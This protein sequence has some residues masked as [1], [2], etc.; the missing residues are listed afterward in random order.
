M[1]NYKVLFDRAIAWAKEN[2]SDSSIYHQAAFGNSVVYL[3]TG[4]SVSYG[5]GPSIREHL[6]SWSLAGDGTRGTI[7][8]NLGSLTVLYP[9]GRITP[10]G[11]WEFTSACLYAAPICFG[12]LSSL[13]KTIQ[14][15]EYCF[16]DDP[17]DL[18]KLKQL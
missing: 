15:Q 7:E 14:Q 12:P 3:C 4:Y 18:E 10:P 2:Y 11:S 17:N 6:V 9:D 13:A 5:G 1:D 8:T 16:D